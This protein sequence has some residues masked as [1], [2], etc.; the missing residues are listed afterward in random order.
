MQKMLLTFFTIFIFCGINAQFWKKKKEKEKVPISTNYSS[1][2]A[3]PDTSTK[4]TGII[5]Y[6]MTTDDPSER[7]SMF[8]IFGENK[9]RFTMFQPGYKA[10]EV[11]E[12][13]MI[14]DF[15][16]SVFYIID[17][18][19]KT[20]TIEKLGARNAG[21]EFAFSNQK[22]T[23]QIL[24][25]PCKEYNGQMQTQEG[26]IYKVNTLVSEKHT[27]LDAKDYNF[28][29]IQPA[30]MGY[31]IVLGYKSVSSNNEN[32]MIIAYKI[33]PGDTKSFFDLKEYRQK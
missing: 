29:N 16:D 31:K 14:A 25:S 22:K 26:D 33:E 3:V 4:F 10:N 27:Y 19:K 32:T 13:N 6:R 11:F 30:I 23:T 28:M 17:V 8:I 7:D 24:Q 15:R 21:I 2:E 12:N 1:D 20:F 18:R 5:K 9:I